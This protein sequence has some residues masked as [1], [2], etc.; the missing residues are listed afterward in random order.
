MSS[1]EPT[2]LDLTGEAADPVEE[3]QQD[4]AEMGTLADFDSRIIAALDLWEHAS[5]TREIGL[6]KAKAQRLVEQLTP[7]LIPNDQ[8]QTG[9]DGLWGLG[10]ETMKGFVH[11]WVRHATQVKEAQVEQVSTVHAEVRHEQAHDVP[12]PPA[13]A[14]AEGTYAQFARQRAI[15][16]EARAGMDALEHA[17]APTALEPPRRFPDSDDEPTRPP[18][19]SRSVSRAATPEPAP[20]RSQRDTIQLEGAFSFLKSL[21]ATISTRYRHDEDWRI[22]RARQ[23]DEDGVRTSRGLDAED[24]DRAQ[25]IWEV[26]NQFLSQ[27]LG[28][29]AVFSKFQSTFWKIRNNPQIDLARMGL[30]GTKTGVDWN[31]VAKPVDVQADWTPVRPSGKQFTVARK[32]QKRFHQYSP[33]KQS[34]LEALWNNKT[35]F[36]NPKN[37]PKRTRTKGWIPKKGVPRHLLQRVLEEFGGPNE[38]EIEITRCTGEDPSQWTVEDMTHDLF[39]SD[40]MQHWQQLSGGQNLAEHVAMINAPMPPPRPKRSR[41]PGIEEAQDDEKSPEAPTGTPGQT[42]PDSPQIPGP[43][44]VHRHREHGEAQLERPA[45]KKGRPNANPRNR[46]PLEENA[47]LGFSTPTYGALDRFDDWKDQVQDDSGFILPSPPDVV[48]AL[49]AHVSDTARKSKPSK[50]RYCI[51]TLMGTTKKG[52]GLANSLLGG[53]LALP[54]FH[55]VLAYLNLVGGDASPASAIHHSKRNDPA[56]WARWFDE[57]FRRVPLDPARAAL[58]HEAELPPEVKQFLRRPD[59]VS[60]YDAVREIVPFCIERDIQNPKKRALFMMKA[61]HLRGAMDRG[62]QNAVA[63]FIGLANT[64]SGDDKGRYMQAAKDLDELGKELSVVTATVRVRG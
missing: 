54:T 48:D 38:G 44:Q 23:L 25:G 56:E 33:A 1:E 15:S 64:A 60:P 30:A 10:P 50:L 20:K 3:A 34:L 24:S 43:I 59:G 32:F 37:L 21:R 7:L 13:R 47:R 29:P 39:Q 58:L 40:W 63:H 12:A 61:A 9:A 22:F 62:K 45:R 35:G 6:A 26:V 19:R 41:S 2:E 36:G 18:R 8:P 51:R 17:R 11:T 27:D 28:N 52:G 53:T 5:G 14:P 16:A 55:T 46:E 31:V 42:D 57:Y 49:I 4:V